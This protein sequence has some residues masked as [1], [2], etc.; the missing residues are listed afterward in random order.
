M[1]GG[2][3]IANFVTLTILHYVLWRGWRNIFCLILF[4]LSEVL[5]GC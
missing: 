5:S 1:T 4:L 2:N 3:E